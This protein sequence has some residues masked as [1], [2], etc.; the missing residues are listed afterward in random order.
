MPKKRAA[1]SA[2]RESPV[3]IDGRIKDTEKI[4]IQNF[5]ALQKV[6]TNLS[7]KFDNLTSQISKLLE[8]FEISAK[9]L[10]KKDF[11]AEK[12]M[13]TNREVVSKLDNL[14]NQNKIIA[15]GLTLLH[16]SGNPMEG[17]TMQKPFKPKPLKQNTYPDMEEGYQKS[18][19]SSNENGNQKP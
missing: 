8:L 14:I 4:L 12:D 15:R 19:S 11:S 2:K 16:E 6:M 5:I 10:A 3:K 13:K 17:D 1:S 18:I 7:F 9:N